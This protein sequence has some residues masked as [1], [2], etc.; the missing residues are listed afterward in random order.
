M[1]LDSALTPPI[2]QAVEEAIVAELN[3]EAARQIVARSVSRTEEV[4]TGV[5]STRAAGAEVLAEQIGSAVGAAAD[6]PTGGGYAGVYPAHGGGA[7]GGGDRC[8]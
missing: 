4:N 1:A 6:D 3:S 7:T 5:Q 2:T 8:P